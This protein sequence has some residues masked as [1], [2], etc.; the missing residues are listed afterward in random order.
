[1][2]STG[3]SA[4]LER[5]SANPPAYVIAADDARRDRIPR[6]RRVVRQFALTPLLVVLAFAALATVSIIADQTQS[7]GVL[8]VIRDDVGHVVGK[9]ASSAALQAI[10]TGLVTVT[11]ITFSVLLLAVQQTASSLSPV[12]FDQFM[13][14]RTNQ[15]FLGFFVGLALFSYVVMAAVQDKTPPILG[16]ALASVLTVVALLILLMLVYSTINQMRPTSVLTALHDRA[17]RARASQAELLRRTRRE[18]TSNQPVRATYVAG[19]TGYVNGVDLKVL[20]RTL[21]GD[22]D[23]EICLEVAVGDHVAYGDTLAT[24]RAGT[25]CDAEALGREL[26]AA[27]QISRQRDLDNDPTTGIDQLGNI[28]WSNGSSSKHNPEVAREVLAALRDLAARWIINDPLTQEESSGPGGPLPLVYPDNDLNR[29]LDALYSLLTVGY[30]SKQYMTAAAALDAYRSLLPHARGS[31]R[32]RLLGEAETAAKLLDQV[33]AA[34]ALQAAR[35]AFAAQAASM[36]DGSAS[37]TSV[38]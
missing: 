21:G 29:L 23:V 30:E 10:A 7:V 20:M 19:V 32:E 8:N 17:L 16:A 11:S 31:L 9:S 4:P 15:A 6:V 27:L 1:M 38:R 24:V 12:V 14:R 22:D 34:P 28:G 33:P 2:S 36:E 37:T 18:P 5:S 35:Q 13:Q 25:G 26:G 3:R